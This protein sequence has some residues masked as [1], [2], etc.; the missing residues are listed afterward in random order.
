MAEGFY[1]TEIIPLGEN[2][3][4]FNH[5][6]KLQ[7]IRFDQATFLSVDLTRSAGVIGQQH[8]Q[9]SLYVALDAAHASPVITLQEQ[10]RAD[11]SPKSQ[12]P[13]LIESR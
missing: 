1:S 6:G 5:R 3:W 12:T 7:T 10:S 4:R 8:F 2:S 9:G 13:Y 11:L